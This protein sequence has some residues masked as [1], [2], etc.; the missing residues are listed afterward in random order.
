MI[1]HLVLMENLTK[2]KYIHVEQK[3]PKCGS[4]WDSIWHASAG[5]DEIL[6]L[7]STISETQFSNLFLSIL[8]LHVSKAALKSSSSKQFSPFMLSLSVFFLLISDCYGIFARCVFLSSIIRQT[9][10]DDHPHTLLLEAWT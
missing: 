6:N 3:G 9:D 2:R 8:W 10:E 1:S 7:L 4:L 5:R